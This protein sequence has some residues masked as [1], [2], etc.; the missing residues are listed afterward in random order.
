[1]R[2]FLDFWESR[3]DGKL[4][5]VGYAHQ[6]LIGPNEWRRVDGEILLN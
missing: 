6:K 4:H 3:L 1:M 5:S 2:K